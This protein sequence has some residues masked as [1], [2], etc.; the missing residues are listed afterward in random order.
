MYQKSISCHA[1]VVEG[2]GAEPLL[3][4]A[5]DNDMELHRYDLPWSYRP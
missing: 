4:Y 3:K 2:A 5:E 1:A